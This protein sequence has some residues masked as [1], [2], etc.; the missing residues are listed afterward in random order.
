[1]DPNALSTFNLHSE[2][3][4][5]GNA[6]VKLNFRISFHATEDAP[7][8]EGA[9]SQA[10]LL[11]ITF[12]QNKKIPTE[13]EEYIVNNLGTFELNESPDG[14]SKTLSFEL[15]INDIDSD[16]ITK[17]YE[18][19]FTK[20]LSEALFEVNYEKSGTI[21]DF[22][23]DLKTFYHVPILLQVL[24]RANIEVRLKDHVKLLEG[25]VQYLKS[26]SELGLA[27]FLK[28]SELFKHLKGNAELISFKGDFEKDL[29]DVGL[30]QRDLMKEFF[31]AF[32]NPLVK[33][34]FEAGQEGSLRI[35]GRILNIMNY[36][37]NFECKG[38]AD[39][40]QKIRTMH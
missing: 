37:V 14:A 33:F 3:F 36:E 34:I 7:L 9:R 24:E 2:A 1:M 11:Q 40:L 27:N 15:K 32:E 29:H 20:R 5:P 38:G 4:T 17:T 28:V 26:Q 31:L 39:L 25:W 23:S 30:D 16:K 10:D 22:F 35:K 21:D 12:S 19:F 6:A 18:D 13:V 8:A